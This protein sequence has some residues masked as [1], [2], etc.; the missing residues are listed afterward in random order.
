M[1]IRGYLPKGVK[2]F[3]DRHPKFD[4]ALKSFSYLFSERIIKILIGFF[5]HALLARH[6]G[7][8]HFGKLSYIVKTVTVFFAFGTFGVDEIIIK[9]LMEGKY[10]EEDILK[11]VFKLRLH[12]SLLG[13]LALGAFI[14]AFRPEGLIFSL[15]T[16]IYGIN[17]ILQAFNVYELKFHSEMNFKPLFWANNFSYISASALRVAGVIFNGS[18][19]FFLS[20]YIWGEISLKWLVLKKVGIK[21][22]FLGESIKPFR[23]LLITESFPFFLSSFVVLLDQRISFLFLE[24]FRDLTELG[25][26]S[27]AVTLVDLWVFLP[28]AICSAIFP[29]IITA[30][31]GNQLK[32]NIR[33]Q[34]LADVL[35]WLA[36]IF[37]AGVI[38]S[39]DQVIK[40]LYG[41]KYLDAPRALSLFS[42]TTIPIFFNL[43]RIKWISL[44]AKFHEWLGISIICLVLNLIGHLVFVPY[45]GVPGAIGSFLVSQVIG[46]AISCLF[47]S[48]ARRSVAIFLKTFTFPIRFIG[49][50][51]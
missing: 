3:I 51:R 38:I 11:T 37:S 4:L 42:L 43:G 17:I 12:G 5:V 33:I 16:F 15:I 14:I 34:Y 30:Y 21:K 39:S 13:L 31:T 41:D 9:H 47:F 35:V 36:I 23:K 49:K 29:T 27:V 50:V 10:K 26:Y 25:N 8:V 6:L 28:M 18:I 40:L 1:G 20:T 22:A 19:S 2:D 46:N 7:P 44:E 32:Y 45:Y 48:S 24:K